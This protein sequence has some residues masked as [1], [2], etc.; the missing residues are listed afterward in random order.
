MNL[1]QRC[2]LFLS[3]AGGFLMLQFAVLPWLGTSNTATVTAAPSGF[4]SLVG[5]PYSGRVLSDADARK[6]LG[7][8]SYPE[9]E[10]SDWDEE[11]EGCDASFWYE[12]CPE[13]LTVFSADG[14]FS[15]ADYTNSKQSGTRE[16]GGGQQAAEA[17]CYSGQVNQLT[18]CTIYTTNP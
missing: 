2:P 17:Y 5:A 13:D 8:S 6:L 4:A 18:G 12:A 3:V 11:D 1:M 14:V 15:I 16:C 7:A 9:P 10:C